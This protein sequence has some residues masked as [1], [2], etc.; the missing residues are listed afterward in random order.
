MV[1][2]NHGEM[3]KHKPDSFQ[4]HETPVLYGAPEVVG[5]LLN[6]EELE[7]AVDELRQSGF[8][9]Q[10]ISVL[11]TRRM[12]GKDGYHATHLEDDPRTRLCAFVS[13]DSRAEIEAAAVGPPI[14]T[15]GATGYV[16]VVASGG[17]LAIALAALLMAGDAGA[18]LGAFLAHT[19]ARHHHDAIAA[20]ITRGGL[21]LWVQVKGL[22]QESK[23]IQV[24]NAHHGRHVHVHDI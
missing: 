20:Q 18:G 7:A 21:M 17:S 15:L 19:I 13:S 4:F 2:A 3:T 1:Q 8:D 9:R 24:L 16:A 12:N 22:A 10:Q 6:D 23:A 5:V 14:Y 11:G